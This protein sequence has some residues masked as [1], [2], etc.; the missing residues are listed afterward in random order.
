MNPIRWMAVKL[1]AREWLPRFAPAIVGVD[2]ILRS[3]SS[4]HFTLLTL[5][6]L[7]EL[8][9]TVRGRKTGR[10]RTTP[11]L[12]TPVGA[13]QP[14]GWIVVGSNWGA[15]QPPAWVGN[16]RAVAEAGERAVVE[17]KARSHVVAPRELHGEER[18]AAWQRAVRTWPNYPLYEQRTQRTLT[19]WL[20]EA[21]D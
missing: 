19:V 18:A 8:F 17:F 14:T 10:P 13:G 3:V 2:R 21:A 1:G 9:L 16:L 20:L 12:C 6:G 7:P 15:A 11:L 4:G 5:T